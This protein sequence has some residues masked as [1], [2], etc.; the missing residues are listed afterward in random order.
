[1]RFDWA[2]SRTE[3]SGV[4]VERG[5][6]GRDSLPA[7]LSGDPPPIAWSANQLIEILGLMEDARVIVAGNGPLN[8]TTW[9]SAE[10]DDSRPIILLMPVRRA[11]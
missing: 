4:S 8:A 1:L 3:I 2:P 11:A 5:S 6:E 7:D 10:G 9:R